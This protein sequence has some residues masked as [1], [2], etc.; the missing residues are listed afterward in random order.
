M[1]VFEHGDIAE[2]DL[3]GLPL[4]AQADMGV[5]P[6]RNVLQHDEVAGDPLSANEDASLAALD[7]E[8]GDHGGHAVRPIRS[9]LDD[10][11]RKV[12]RL[13]HEPGPLQGDPMQIHPAKLDRFLD[14][15]LV[16]RDVKNP[17]PLVR[18]AV[19]NPNTLLQ[20]AR[21]VRAT[22]LALRARLPLD[23]GLSAGDVPHVGVVTRRHVAVAQMVVA[24]AMANPVAMPDAHLLHVLLRHVL[25]LRHMRLRLRLR[26]R[27]L[28]LRRVLAAA[29]AANGR[30][31][32]HHRSA[33]PTGVV[34]HLLAFQ[35]V[36]A[37]AAATAEGRTEHR[38]RFL[39]GWYHRRRH[40]HALAL[41][42]LLPQCRPP[43][44][45][46][47]VGQ[48]RLAKRDGHQERNDQYSQ[49]KTYPGDQNRSDR[50]E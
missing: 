28:L 21:T 16:R 45:T 12:G 5:I 2:L 8:P 19:H 33:G 10:D 25:L 7:G 29:G 13:A 15:D 39:P 37:A 18:N 17:V 3:E 38:C 23:E 6:Q 47:A 14:D 49:Q 27:Q 24:V 1:A 42:P 46:L 35:C 20:A 30:R 26:L 36:G 31:R 44:R 11:A 43:R 32:R 4:D 9:R 41:A 34:V 50:R 22:L 40:L 48:T